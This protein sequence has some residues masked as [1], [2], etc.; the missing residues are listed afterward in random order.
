M[1]IY[2]EDKDLSDIKRAI[3]IA[4]QNLDSTGNGPDKMLSDR[5][6]TIKDKL[7]DHHNHLK[8]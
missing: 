3:I 4:M 5:L 2:L 7:D 1:I 8:F 6:E